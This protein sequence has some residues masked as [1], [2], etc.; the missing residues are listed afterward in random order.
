VPETHAVAAPDPD[1]PEAASHRNMAANLT[2]PFSAGARDQAVG[3]DAAGRAAVTRSSREPL[4][5][6]APATDLQRRGLRLR[7][8][9]DP[10]GSA[11]SLGPLDFA[12]WTEAGSFLP[13]HR[14]ASDPVTATAAPFTLALTLAE[15]GPDGAEAPLDPGL[16]AGRVELRLLEGVLGRVLYALGAEKQR[17]RRTGRQVAAARRLADAAGDALDRAA[18]EV[19]VAR[20]ADRL[21]VRDG[22]VQAD[23][24]REPDD[25]LRRR[26]AL[27][28]PWLVPTR[29]RMLELLNGP[30]AD[31]DPN[32][33][34]LAGL[35]VA[36]ASPWS[37]A[38]TRSP[39][40][41]TW[42]RPT[43]PRRG[44][45]SSTGSAPPT[46][47]G[48]RTRRRATP[49]TPPATCP[50]QP[51]SGSPG[52]AATCGPSSPSGATPP[53]TRPSR[54]SSPTRWCG[55]GAAGRRWAS[56]PH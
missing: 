7:A 56:P 36:T 27:Y 4:L 52:S 55:W 46:W 13:L 2:V 20:F 34:P 38:T 1:G 31:T 6:A 14:P 32:A 18:A 12:S 17:L 15:V 26:V 5:L 10:E 45:T 47:S 48:P 44:A 22:E 35:G 28:R 43:T 53:P 19:G 8:V 24:R 30:G 25:E 42:S 50:R 39:S 29:G 33:G 37:R 54:P 40:R 49:S 11:T 3:I 51:G 21:V 41:S 16:V 23:P 9:L